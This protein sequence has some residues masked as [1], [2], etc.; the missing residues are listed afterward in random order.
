MQPGSLDRHTGRL[1]GRWV[2]DRVRFKDAM[3]EGAGTEFV[4]HA[5]EFD[6][7]IP[8]VLFSRAAL[9]K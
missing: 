6:I 2:P 4:I 8:D 9:K 1:G 7:P 5:I 3:N